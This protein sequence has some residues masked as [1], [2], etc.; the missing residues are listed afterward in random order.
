MSWD[1]LGLFL[2]G[3]IL[4][5]IKA[6]L[7]WLMRWGGFGRSWG[8][9][10]LGGALTLGIGAVALLGAPKPLF[11]VLRGV[12]RAVDVPGLVSG[13]PDL[14][15]A[16]VLGNLLSTVGDTGALLLLGPRGWRTPVKA[17]F[18]NGVLCVLLLVLL[19]L[20]TTP[21]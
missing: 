20:L 17:L 18:V 21:F 12:S 8:V 4:I 2:A 3:V 7:L 1:F 10:L 16:L 9:V 19:L 15:A 11:A 5:S 6:G 13:L 14:I